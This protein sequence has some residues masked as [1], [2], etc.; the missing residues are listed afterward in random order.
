VTTDDLSII[1]TIVA[2]V[3]LVSAT[4]TLLEAVFTSDK[5][6]DDERKPQ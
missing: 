4:A 2:L 6:D 3:A 1:L 5:D